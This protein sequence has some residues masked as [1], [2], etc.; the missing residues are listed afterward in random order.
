LLWSLRTEE[1]T[2]KAEDDGVGV[3]RFV[4][5]IGVLIGVFLEV[6]AYT[7]AVVI[8]DSGVVAYSLLLKE[9][10]VGVLQEE[11]G[12]DSGRTEDEARVSD[13][14]E[15]EPA[16]LVSLGIVDGLQRRFCLLAVRRVL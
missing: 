15:D 10:L 4:T 8:R 12:R 6:T 5:S 16:D 11:E 3:V 14:A 13:R 9:Y 1:A 7:A 2:D